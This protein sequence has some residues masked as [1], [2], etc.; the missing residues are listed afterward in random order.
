MSESEQETRGYHNIPEP[1]DIGEV[2]RITGRSKTSIYE[3]PTFPPPISFTEP[4]R[5]VRHSRWL[6]HEVVQWLL[7]KIAQRDAKVEA[8]TQELIARQERKRQKQSAA[9]SRTQHVE[10]LDHPTLRAKRTT[11]AN[12]ARSSLPRKPGAS[13][14]V[15]ATSAATEWPEA[16]HRRR[17]R[18][19]FNKVLSPTWRLIDE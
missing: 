14:A 17:R 13:L 10:A 12:V 2:R 5:V 1:I 7:D 18:H 16:L 3:D 4:G 19:L 6:K 9:P 11:R 8:R 15:A